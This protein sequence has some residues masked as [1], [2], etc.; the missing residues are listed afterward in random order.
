MLGLLPTLV[1]PLNPIECQYFSENSSQHIFYL[2]NVG[3][4]IVNPPFGNGK[5]TPIYGDD[6]GMVYDCFTN[7][8]GSPNLPIRLPRPPT[9]RIV[10]VPV[11]LESVDTNG[12]IFQCP[13]NSSLCP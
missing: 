13:M 4:T 11:S 2:D 12:N 6:W 1:E 3:K 10:V 5:H 8:F 9:S 7:Q